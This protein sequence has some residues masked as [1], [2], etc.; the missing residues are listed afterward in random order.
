VY[1]GRSGTVARPKERM[2]ARGERRRR[3]VS[4]YVC[5]RRIGQDWRVWMG[6]RRAET[7]AAKDIATL[8]V[9]GERGSRGGGEI[10]PT[11]AVAALGSHGRRTCRGVHGWG[12]ERVEEGGAGHGLCSRILEHRPRRSAV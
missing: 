9:R 4:V 11:R 1:G 3:D 8:V 6:S 10:K 7:R 2:N 12:G 5:T